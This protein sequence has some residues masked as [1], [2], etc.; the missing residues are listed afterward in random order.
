VRQFDL[1]Q[2]S[3]FYTR[4]G[5]TARPAPFGLVS[6][7]DT[8]DERNPPLI[9]YRRHGIDLNTIS[10]STSQ[11][12]YIALGGSHLY[13]FLHDRRMLGRDRLQEAGQTYTRIPLKEPDDESLAG[14]TKCVRRFAPRMGMNWDKRM[15]NSHVT[16]CKIS[17]ANPNE[18]VASWSGDGVYLFHINQSPHPN[19]LGIGREPWDPKESLRQRRAKRE[20]VAKARARKRR[21]SRSPSVASS[22]DVVVGQSMR[23]ICSL[24]AE[25]RGELF[26][27]SSSNFEVDD[28]GQTAERKKSYDAALALAHTALKRIHRS[29]EYLD[30]KDIEVLE[31]LGVTRSHSAL[32]SERARRSA[33]AKNRRRARAFVMAA[34]CI[35]RAVGG[36]V[37][38]IGIGVGAFGTISNG[39]NEATSFRYRFLNAIVAFLDS[40]VDGVKEQAELRYLEEAELEDA[41]FE[42]SEQ[43]PLPPP[44]SEE[45]LDSYL[46][47]L[48]RGAQP[49]PIRDVDSNEHLFDSEINM[50][51]A[52]RR[53][54]EIH[55]S[56][57]ATAGNTANKFWGERI[58]RAVLMKEGE[59]IDYSF[60]EAAFDGED[61][62][63][64]LLEDTP[65]PE[66]VP[67]T[68]LAADE[69]DDGSDAGNED[70]DMP[71]LVEEGDSEEEDSDDDD[72]DD[73]DDD[74]DNAGDEDMGSE[75]EGDSE[76]EDDFWYR[77][78]RNNRGPVEGHAPVWQHTKVYRGHC[79]LNASS[80]DIY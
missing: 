35:A 31:M 63:E 14:A 36:F 53:A 20:R 4:P 3:S 11:P 13:C 67:N 6:F 78:R 62:P 75:D 43:S 77:R 71:L 26:G 8:E 15:I 33:L 41:E 39:L 40:G 64:V 42:T 47:A 17:D 38:G 2:P 45:K 25:I 27:Y 70:T 29:I 49:S 51:R 16:A 1:R 80:L 34:G 57:A 23:K 46:T 48:E 7:T 30:Q 61:G 55:S 66:Q 28:A 76:D 74:Y 32:Q 19:E 12:H 5:G 58:A 24:V 37:E 21:R 68:L 10:C 69:G 73:D 22:E 56:E 79:K 50:V 9:S 60:V 65:G 18:V 52:F 59:A 44:P 54:L 72:D